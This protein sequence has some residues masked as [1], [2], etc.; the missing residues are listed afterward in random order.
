MIVHTRRIVD[1]IGM[2]L[3]VFGTLPAAQAENAII[4][5][6]SSVTIP[7]P[8]Q[9]RSAVIDS[10]T[11]ALL[12][13]DMS[14][15]SCI[16]EKRPSCV[17]SLPAVKRLLDQARSHHMLVLYS[18]GV[19]SPLVPSYVAPAIAPIPGEQIL[20]APVDKFFKS[21]LEKILVGK[22]IK[23]V[24]V[25]GTSAEGAVLYTASGAALRGMTAI[26]PVDCYSAI[27]PFAE[28][29]T[30]WHLINAPT[31]VSSHILLT[32]SDRITFP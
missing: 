17:R 6:W 19:A 14:A 31:A 2:L 8:A 1:T 29:Y 16:N 11:T 15:I 18:A 30:A 4:G 20:G 28:M 3:A 24:I 5:R 25:T 26:V 23:T 21:D 32:S 22:G 10:A 7:K 12:I 13:L 27:E 9:L